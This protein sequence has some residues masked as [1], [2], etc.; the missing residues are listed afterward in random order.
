MAKKKKGYKLSQ[1]DKSKGKVD[2]KYY[3]WVLFYL[4][5]SGCMDQGY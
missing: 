4:D 3:K 1:K 5:W 2:I